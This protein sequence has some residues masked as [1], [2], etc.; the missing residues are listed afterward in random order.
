[1]ESDI[2]HL[3][4]EALKSSVSGLRGLKSVATRLRPEMVPDSARDWLDHCLDPE[5]REKL[6]LEQIAWIFAQAKAAGSHAGFEMFARL[7]GYHVVAVVD[8]REEFRAMVHRAEQNLRE[9]TELSQKALAYAHST[10]LKVDE[11]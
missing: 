1:M 10:H 5:R 4:H 8:P 2:D 9:A 6:S 3:P 7:C 11:P